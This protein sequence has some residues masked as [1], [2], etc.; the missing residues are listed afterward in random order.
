MSDSLGLKIIWNGRKKPNRTVVALLEKIDEC[1]GARD[2]YVTGT[3]R[4]EKTNMSVGGEKNSLHLTGRA[5]DFYVPG[6]SSEDTAAQAVSVGAKGVGAYDKAH[7]GHT[8]IDDRRQG[9]N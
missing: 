9:R 3:V 8:H 6:Q 7:G 1:N 4:D 2:V 5:V